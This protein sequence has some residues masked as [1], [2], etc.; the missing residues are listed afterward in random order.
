MSLELAA[1]SLGE[2]TG[3]AQRCHCDCEKLRQ[4]MESSLVAEVFSHPVSLFLLFS[5]FFRSSNSDHQGFL[6]LECY[7]SCR[8]LVACHLLPGS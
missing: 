5:F 6:K 3:T 7:M 8:P 2:A 4:E 1:E